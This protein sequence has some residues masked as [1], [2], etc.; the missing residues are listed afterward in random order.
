VLPSRHG[1]AEFLGLML[2]SAS[3][4]K[5]PRSEGPVILAISVR[6]AE[7]AFG[8]ATLDSRAEAESAFGMATL[9]SRAEAESDFGMAT[10]DSSAET[11]FGMATLDSKAAEAFMATLDS[12]AA[13]AFMQAWPLVAHWFAFYREAISD[14]YFRAREESLMEACFEAWWNEAFMDSTSQ[15]DDDS[16]ELSEQFSEPEGVRVDHWYNWLYSQGDQSRRAHD[17]CVYK[18]N[19]ACSYICASLGASSYMRHSRL[20][21]PVDKVV[22]LKLIVILLRAQS[23]EPL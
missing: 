9:D 18:L 22:V 3:M 11:A 19:Q 17:V 13:A 16:D 4:S 7:S 10:L 8:M 5:L 20:N 6:R 14:E 12:T 2:A 21:M 23:W 15:M 1:N